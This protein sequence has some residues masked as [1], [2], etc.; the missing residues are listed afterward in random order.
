MKELKTYQEQPQINNNNALIEA[1]FVGGEVFFVLPN[2]KEAIKLVSIAKQVVTGENKTVREINKAKK[3]IVAV[4]NALGVNAANV[5]RGAFNIGIAFAQGGAKGA[6]GVLSQIGGTIKTTR[7]QEQ[8]R[9]QI[10][11][12]QIHSLSKWKALLDSGAISQ[13]EFDEKKREIINKTK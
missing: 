6:L 7:E 3:N 13:E 2:K 1:C 11:D 5:A 12:E 10:E 4:G 8:E 9:L